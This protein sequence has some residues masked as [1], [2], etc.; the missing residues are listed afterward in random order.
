MMMMSFHLLT[1]LN[2]LIC[3]DLIG[4]GID[5]DSVEY[6]VSYDAPAYMD[7]Y[8]HRVGRTAR[9][10]REGIAYTLVEKPQAR[11]FKEMM[12]H[13]GHLDQIQT[14]NIEKEKIQELVSDYEKAMESVTTDNNDI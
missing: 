2:R 8:I 6:V 3:S 13:A 4:R 7:K 9:A 14:L 1:F 5:L 12:R 11:H 10:G